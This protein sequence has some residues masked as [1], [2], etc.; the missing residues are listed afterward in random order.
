MEMTDIH[1]GEHIIAWYDE[2]VVFLTFVLN[3]VTIVIL[4][5]IFPDIMDE[6]AKVQA[7]YQVQEKLDRK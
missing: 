6:L 2:D 1:S 4:R 5:E 7:V 3:G